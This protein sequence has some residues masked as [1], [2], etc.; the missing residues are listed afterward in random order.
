MERARKN[1][2]LYMVISVLLAIV[3]WTY[4]GNENPDESGPV[5]NLPV[6][7]TGVELLESRGLMITD[8]LEQ[9]VTLNVTGKRNAFRL[10]SSET[11]SITVDVSSIQQP[12]QYTQAYQVA[13]NLP[14][15]TSSSSLVVTERYPLNV[16]FTVA[17]MATRNIPVQ[18][19]MT[20]SVAENYQAGEF[21]FSPSTIKVSGEESVVN[22]IDFAQ[23]TLNQEDMD[24]TYDGDLPYTF[25]SF[26][27]EAL[28]DIDVTADAALVHT[29]LPIVKL[30]EVPLTVNLIPGGG[31]SADDIDRYTQ[32]TIVP[33]SIMVSGAAADLEPLKEISLGDIDLSKVL[34]TNTVSF[35][36]PL[37]AELTNV[38]GVSEAVVQLSITGL[39]TATLE[40]DN[41]ECI[42]KP[43]GY[44]ADPL[45]TS[46][47]V[48]IRGTQEAVSAVTASQ[49]RIVADLDNAVAATGTQ[50]IPV[51]VYLDG[52]SDVGVVGDYNIVVSISRG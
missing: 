47:Q 43:D 26:T 16:T 4:V 34:G 12:G 11:V 17:K 36:I 35:T 24:A 45:T 18:G 10:L 21:S 25:I 52:R 40:V 20:G 14:G 8:G 15:N 22:R 30:K 39:T 46:R 23:V 48:Q 27:G 50:T 29:T 9:S 31:I 13:Y 42:N 6:T 51:K 37:A 3:L 32:Y 2:G 38:S 19:S 5:R 7:F 49:L 41:I 44:T 28:E 1:K 33:K